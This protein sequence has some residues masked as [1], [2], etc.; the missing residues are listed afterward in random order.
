MYAP[1]FPYNLSLTWA[2]LPRAIR[3]QGTP[4]PLINNALHP[5]AHE[6][7]APPAVDHASSV[8]M[9]PRSSDD[10]S[11][12]RFCLASGVHVQDVQGWSPQAATVAT[13]KHTVTEAVGMA[14]T[15]AIRK[16]LPG[17]PGDP[18][19][20]GIQCHR[21]VVLAVRQGQAD[22]IEMDTGR[23]AS[24]YAK[25]VFITVMFEAYYGMFGEYMPGDTSSAALKARASVPAPAET[26]SPFALDDD[27]DELEPQPEPE[28]EPEPANK[29]KPGPISGKAVARLDEAL[30]ALDRQINEIADSEGKSPQA[31]WRAAKTL[32]PQGRNPNLWNIYQQMWYS[33][34]TEKTK[35]EDRGE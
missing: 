15:A 16:L 29:K 23:Q 5:A 1:S 11:L 34:Y 13:T 2:V 18:E 33:D 12:I 10:V 8:C 4:P 26:I 30:Q 3:F 22:V 35:E 6:S 32:F 7:M 9:L 27:D 14:V 19:S 21:K 25:H 28:P 24:D 20:S 31:V 17:L